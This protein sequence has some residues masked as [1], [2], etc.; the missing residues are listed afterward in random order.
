MGRLTCRMSRAPSSV[1]RPFSGLYTC[2]PLMMTVCAGR[3]TPQ[4]SVAVDTSTWK[5]SSAV[6]PALE[7]L[8]VYTVKTTQRQEE[9]GR[10][11]EETGRKQEETGR[12]QEETGRKQEDR[13]RKQ[14]ETGRKELT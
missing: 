13:G 3:L 8:P 11:Q 5:Q 12:K 9:T 2:V 1:Q 4:A 7:E 10:K 14:E 6:R